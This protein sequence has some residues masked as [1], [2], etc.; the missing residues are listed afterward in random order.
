VLALLV[1]V[2]LADRLALKGREFLWPRPRPVPLARWLLRKARPGA[3]YGPAR[4]APPRQPVQ[5]PYGARQVQALFERCGFQV[6]RVISRARA[7]EAPLPGDYMRFYC[8]DAV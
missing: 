7:P 5:N 8:L 1:D 6:T 4:P 3:P 2:T